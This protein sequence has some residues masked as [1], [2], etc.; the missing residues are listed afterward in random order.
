M[1]RVVGNEFVLL[2]NKRF[3]T[4][5]CQH[6]RSQTRWSLCSGPEQLNNNK[7]LV[8]LPGKTGPGRVSG[9]NDSDRY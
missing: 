3:L 2:F 6:L 4:K 5:K 1:G 7:F 9:D 8:S